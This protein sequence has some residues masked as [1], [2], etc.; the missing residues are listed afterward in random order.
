MSSSLIRHDT[1]DFGRFRCDIMIES[2]VWF[3]FQVIGSVIFIFVSAN[4]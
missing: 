1:L 3:H 4:K 2:T